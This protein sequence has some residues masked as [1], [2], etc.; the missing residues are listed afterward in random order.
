MYKFKRRKL[1]DYLEI[2]KET[3]ELEWIKNYMKFLI[4]L[5]SKKCMKITI[6]F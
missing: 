3:K 2:Y 4:Y 1:V 5:K 6:K